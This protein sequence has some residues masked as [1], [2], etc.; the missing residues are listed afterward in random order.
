MAEPFVFGAVNS[1]LVKLSSYAYK[2]ASQ[3]F[4]AYVN[5][6]QFKD[7]LLIVRGVLLDAEEEEKDQKHGFRE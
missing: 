6:P 7:T 3:A 4:G 1:L 5:L 2:E